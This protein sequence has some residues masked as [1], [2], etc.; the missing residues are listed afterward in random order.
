MRAAVDDTKFLCILTDGVS[1][2]AN[3]LDIP[4]GGTKTVSQQGTKLCVLYSCFNRIKRHS[5]SN[6]KKINKCFCRYKKR[7][8]R[9]K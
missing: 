1:Y 5:R 6:S 9:N 8:H 3:V 4:V 7:K 2:D